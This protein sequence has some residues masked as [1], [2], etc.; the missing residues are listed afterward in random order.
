MSLPVACIGSVAH[1]DEPLRPVRVDL[2]MTDANY[3]AEL[4][5]AEPVTLTTTLDDLLGKRPV[6]VLLLMRTRRG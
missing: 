5:G 3:A 6:D 1:T 2:G 4:A